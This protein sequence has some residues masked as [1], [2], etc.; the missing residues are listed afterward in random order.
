MPSGTCTSSSHV[1][2]LPY[3][4]PRPCRCSPPY[5]PGYSPVASRHGL[6]L[7]RTARKSIAGPSTT[8]FHFTPTLAGPA[9][10]PSRQ[11]LAYPPRAPI[12]ISSTD[13]PTTD[14]GQSEELQ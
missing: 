11:V 9:A 14:V 1:P 10:G 3:F 2:Y 6:H 8:V 7:I 12:D 13:E 4:S 5:T